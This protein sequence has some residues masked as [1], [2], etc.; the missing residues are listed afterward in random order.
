MFVI[1]GEGLPSSRK[2]AR[3]DLFVRFAPPLFS[4]PHWLSLFFSLSPLN[5]SFKL[6]TAVPPA[7]LTEDVVRAL[8]ACVSA[9]GS[10]GG[11]PAKGSAGQAAPAAP[12]APAIP[13]D[14]IELAFDPTPVSMCDFGESPC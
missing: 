3:G 6:D 14:S 8:R 9:P 1:R 12:V 13:A 11:S 10:K 4:S 7:L 5:R 2:A